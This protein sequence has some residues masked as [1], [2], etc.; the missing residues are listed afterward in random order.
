MRASQLISARLESIVRAEG[1]HPGPRSTGTRSLVRRCWRAGNSRRRAC[2]SG[3]QSS[4]NAF[5]LP[6]S[7]KSDACCENCRICLTCRAR[8]CFCFTVPTRVPN[9]FCTQCRPRK[10]RPRMRLST[11]GQFGQRS[12]NFWRSPTSTVES[13]CSTPG[14]LP[15][16]RFWWPIGLAS[17][18]R[19][20]ANSPSSLLGSLG[21]PAFGNATKT[22]GRSKPMRAARG[23]GGMNGR[24]GMFYSAER[25]RRPRTLSRQGPGSSRTQHFLS[26]APPLHPV[27]EFPSFAMLC[28]PRQSRMPV[29]GC[30][31]PP[32]TRVR[33]S[34]LWTCESPR[35]RLRLPPPLASQ[36]AECRAVVDQRGNYHAACARSHCAG[37]RRRTGLSPN[38]GWR[39]P[40]RQALRK[41]TGTGSTLSFSASLGA[42]RHSPKT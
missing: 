11:I 20:D 14:R 38:S 18:E 13:G 2:R 21:G 40:P 4:S 33:N 22:P 15:P 37:S 34:Y 3:T 16:R 12:S 17:A 28:F 31:P 39:E 41:M 9:T 8:D 35:R 32:Q 42:A 10:T 1:H 26:R 24:S 30:E 23:K 19:I 25:S 7:R 6:D 27:A 36:A 29:S 5:P